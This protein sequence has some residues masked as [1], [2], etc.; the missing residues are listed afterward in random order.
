MTGYQFSDMSMFQIWEW[1]VICVAKFSNTL[2]LT[3]TL[4]KVLNSYQN[5]S[6]SRVTALFSGG[7]G[8]GL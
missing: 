3:D 5:G 8:G 2:I 7:G 6:D 1:H 4:L